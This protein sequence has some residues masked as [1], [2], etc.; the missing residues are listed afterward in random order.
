[1][2]NW[3]GGGGCIDGGGGIKAFWEPNDDIEEEEEEVRILVH[4]EVNKGNEGKRER[5]DRGHKLQWGK[6]YQLR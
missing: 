5:R 1:M 3:E 2:V 4:I 6:K